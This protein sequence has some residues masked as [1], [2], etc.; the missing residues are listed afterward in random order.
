MQQIFVKSALLADG[1]ADNIL[2][3]IRGGKITAIEQ[4]AGPTVDCQD[5]G[6]QILLPALANVHSHSFQRAMAGLSER[7][8]ASTDSFWTWRDVM[9]R[10]LDKLSVDDIHA[11]AAFTFMEMAEAG[12]AS[13]GEFHYVHH[14]KC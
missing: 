2:I 5:L 11:I 1:W 10:F 13:V 3:S 9:Y 7:R 6:A 14:Q 4:D 12:F 8:G